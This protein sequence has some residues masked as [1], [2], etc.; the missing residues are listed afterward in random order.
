MPRTTVT[1][2]LGA[3]WLYLEVFYSHLTSQ[4][5]TRSHSFSLSLV[6][7]PSH[8]ILTWLSLT[9]PQTLILISLSSFTRYLSHTL[10]LPPLYL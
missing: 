7:P 3:D 9:L 4:S 5:L 10:L 2:S 1:M 6:S 8:I